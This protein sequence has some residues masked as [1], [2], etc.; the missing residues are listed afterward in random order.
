M[1]CSFVRCAIIASVLTLLRSAVANSAAAGLAAGGADLLDQWKQPP[2]TRA[3]TAATAKTAGIAFDLFTIA[4]RLDRR[5]CVP[6]CGCGFHRGQSSDM[7]RVERCKR[8]VA[9][10]KPGQR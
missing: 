2:V 3:R 6:L 9:H 7:Q 5:R 10:H 8:D 1:S 4:P